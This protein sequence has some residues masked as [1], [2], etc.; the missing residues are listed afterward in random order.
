MAKPPLA[1]TLS[2]RTGMPRSIAEPLVDFGIDA[3]S[4]A[5][6]MGVGKVLSGGNLKRAQ[7]ALS[8]SVGGLSE[9]MSQKAR[10]L[11]FSQTQ[12]AGDKAARGT[13]NAAET[14]RKTKMLEAQHA[15]STEAA[16]AAVN[17]ASGKALESSLARPKTKDEI[18][19]VLKDEL[20]GAMK[21][22]YEARATQAKDL[23]GKALDTA[24]RQELAGNSFAASKQG[25]Q[26]IADL[27]DLKR[28]VPGVKPLTP[29]HGPK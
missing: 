1:S 26:A 3:G 6:G 27:R 19:G 10:D 20:G 4:V 9:R 2:E 14:A 21:S 23:Y 28:T 17:D 5:G 13:L 29:E 22:A 18:G 25:Q 12:Q 24:H 16:T 11:G 7:G 8:E 15:T